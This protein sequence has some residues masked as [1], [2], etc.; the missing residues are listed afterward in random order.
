M[1]VRKRDRAPA[2]RR[3]PAL[4]LLL[5]LDLVLGA[6]DAGAHA[7]LLDTVPADG[8]V[9][10]EPPAM[11]LLRFNEAVALISIRLLNGD[12][13]AVAGAGAATAMGGEVRL[14]LG[15][16]LAEGS[17]VLSYRVTSLDSHPVAG[18]VT[19]AVGVEGPPSGDGHFS[20]RADS[21]LAEWL[22]GANRALHLAALL[23][24][25]GLALCS[26]LLP[27]PS[28]LAGHCGRGLALAATFGVVTA[29][30]GVGLGGLVLAGTDLAQLLVPATWALG[31]GASLA[32]RSGVA[33][34]GL[35]VLL[36]AGRLTDSG[37]RAA[38]LGVGAAL[39]VAS[40]GFS[41]H[42]ATAQPPWLM[43]PALILHVLAA[44]LW[45]GSLWGLYRIVRRQPTGVAAPLVGSFSVQATWA[46]AAL[47][48]SAGILAWIQLGSPRWLLTTDYG[49]LLL[50]KL[51]LVS[52]LLT[53]AAA[54]RWRF[55]PALAR[56]DAAARRHLALSIALE[57]VTGAAVIAVTAVLSATP[58]PRAMV[59]DA[60]AVVTERPEQATAEA[61][62]DGVTLSV[63]LTPAQAG[64]NRVV[65]RLSGRERGPVSP[66]AVSMSW[67]HPEAG[68]EPL[69]RSASRHPDGH[70]QIEAAPFP[71]RGRWQLRVEAR[72]DD[73]TQIVFDT[74]VVVH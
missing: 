65:L 40:V 16:L 73:F 44:G 21:P 74:A 66:E 51:C 13:Q 4:L 53:L 61:E 14:P 69:R 63:T 26:L 7:V 25:V 15:T 45:L 43:T 2:P 56:G 33:T 41:G 35:L 47:L 29:I 67:S 55:A 72:I 17:Y 34:L 57:L 10:A 3:R 42:A 38:A 27:A 68:I 9:L 11:L 24:A 71:I 37:L 28:S 52:W 32:S 50:T 70:Y 62:S 39:A 12:G 1:A 64:P 19:F 46:V 22:A 23:S 30:L 60:L 18:S 49:Q 8:A 20:A 59:E 58:P 36:G 54:N 5:M 31:G 48:V 6:R